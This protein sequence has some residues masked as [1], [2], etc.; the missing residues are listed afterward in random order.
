MYFTI[1]PYQEKMNE[2]IIQLY[3]E[4]PIP[5]EYLAPLSD[6]IAEDIIQLEYIFYVPQVRKYLMPFEDIELS[7]IVFAEVDVL[8]NKVLPNPLY[9]TQKVIGEA[10]TSVHELIKIVEYPYTFEQMCQKGSGE[11]MC[12]NIA[13]FGIRIDDKGGF[14]LFDYSYPN[15]NQPLDMTLD[16]INSKFGDYVL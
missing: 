13:N 3:A 10:Y 11:Y 8:N 5:N 14:H 16:I 4:I 1:K 7:R 6:L 2:H 9:Y 15:K 12:Q